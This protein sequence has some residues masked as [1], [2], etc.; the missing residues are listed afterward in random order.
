VQTVASLALLLPWLL[1]VFA[2]AAGAVRRMRGRIAA[3][4]AV[5]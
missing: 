1:L 5:G 3:L 4:Q 2:V